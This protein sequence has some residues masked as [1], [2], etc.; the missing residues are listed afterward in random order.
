MPFPWAALGIGAGLGLLKNVE[1]QAQAAAQRKAEAAKT[2]YSPWT[3]MMGQAVRSPSLIGDVV[4]GGATGA[5]LG[6][7]LESAGTL[8]PGAAGKEFVASPEAMQG[9]AAKGGSSAAAGGTYSLMNPAASFGESSA[10][11]LA[12]SLPTD[13]A[14]S[15]L[16]RYMQL[17]G[18]QPGAGGTSFMNPYASMLGR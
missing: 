3:G 15:S 16:A 1:G 4:Q 14:S 17:Y 12:A 2:R 9:L 11:P 5:M 13:S 10:M 18:Q 6:Q 8:G 7:S